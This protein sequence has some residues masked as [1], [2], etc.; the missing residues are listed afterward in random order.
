MNPPSN[1]GSP[2]NKLTSQQRA[3]E[4]QTTAHQQQTKPG[5][6]FA[7]VEEML[8]H[9]ASQTPVPPAIESR[10]QESLTQSATTEPS[11]WRRFFRRPKE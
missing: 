7:S 1:H 11:W 10:L 2:G 4:Q 3:Q 5:V 6:E 8:R 9:D